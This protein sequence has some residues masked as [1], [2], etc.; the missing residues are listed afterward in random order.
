MQAFKLC[1]L[2]R[3]LNN[4]NRRTNIDLQ[5]THPHFLYHLSIQNPGQMYNVFLLIDILILL[6][7]T[8]PLMVGMLY[9]CLYLHNHLIIENIWK[10]PRLLKLVLTCHHCK[11]KRLHFQYRNSLYFRNIKKENLLNEFALFKKSQSGFLENIGIEC[12]HYFFFISRPQH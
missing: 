12:F 1:I 8:S 6:G 7:L 3:F 10:K 2:M 5:L 11:F 9:K 4:Q